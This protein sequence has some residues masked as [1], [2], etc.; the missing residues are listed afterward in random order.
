MCVFP[1]GRGLGSG[2]REGKRGKSRLGKN[3]LE[4]RAKQTRK[5]GMMAV[6]LIHETF[7][8]VPSEFRGAAGFPLG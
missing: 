5:S 7:P 8:W 2:P 1:W 4:E 3:S 6:L